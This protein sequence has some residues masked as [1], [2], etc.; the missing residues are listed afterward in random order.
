MSLLCLIFIDSL[1]KINRF[2]KKWLMFLNF[3]TH[4][5]EP[6][7]SYGTVKLA[8]AEKKPLHY[9]SILTNF[10][11]LLFYRFRFGSFWLWLEWLRILNHNTRIESAKVYRNVCVVLL[12]NIFLIHFTR[13]EKCKWFQFQDNLKKTSKS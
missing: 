9:N 1:S 13:Q 11:R 5:T 8:H 2:L 7:G 4:K 10:R 3:T 6:A 12:Q